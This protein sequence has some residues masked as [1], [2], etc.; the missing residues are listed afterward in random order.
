M[1]LHDEA[2][3]A[4]ADFVGGRANHKPVGQLG[5]A[6]RI[7]GKEP[8][9]IVGRGELKD[10]E[11]HEVEAVHISYDKLLAYR[12][13]EGKKVLWLVLPLGSRTTFDEIRVMSGSNPRTAKLA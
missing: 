6:R 5:R 4:I 11:L 1:T 9:V 3:T 2:I 10:C 13:F 12:K 8:D 7:R